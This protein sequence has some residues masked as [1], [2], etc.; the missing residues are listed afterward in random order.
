MPLVFLDSCEPFYRVLEWN[1]DRQKSLNWQMTHRQTWR[2]ALS[3]LFV[4]KNPSRQVAHGVSDTLVSRAA[5]P[6]PRSERRSLSPPD[7]FK[8]VF[9]A[10]KCFARSGEP[11]PEELR[12]KQTNVCPSA[13]HTHIYPVVLL[14]QLPWCNEKKVANR[15][16]K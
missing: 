5:N 4:T 2:F 7:H 16:P 10:M 11:P 15:R 9:G 8:A 6:S 14:H 13:V 12:N 1:L 3:T